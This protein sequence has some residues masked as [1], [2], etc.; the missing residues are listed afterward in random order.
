MMKN[1][2]RKVILTPEKALTWLDFAKWAPSGGN[3]QPWRVEY[4][5]NYNS[6]AFRLAIEPVCKTNSSLMDVRGAASA[7]A[8][9]ALA[10][11][12]N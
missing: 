9:G 11:N 2:Q 10:E 12:L 8:L 1:E 5:E 4:E 3:A 7:M 6:I